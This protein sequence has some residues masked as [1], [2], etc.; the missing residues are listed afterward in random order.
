ML[1][2]RALAIGEQIAGREV[3][4]NWIEDA[5]FICRRGM[6]GA[7]GNIY[8]GLDEFADIAFLMHLLRPG[9]LFV[10]IG[11]NIG[12][13]T[14]LASAVCGSGAIAVEPDPKR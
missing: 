10:D 2:F 4:F 12:T 14:V 5:K 1:A 8:C 6:T 7:T 13:F 3:V 9:D 11:S